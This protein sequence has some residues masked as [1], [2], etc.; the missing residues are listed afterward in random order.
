MIAVFL[1]LVRLC[2]FYKKSN[3]F[4]FRLYSERLFTLAV[5]F[6]YIPEERSETSWISNSYLL[7]LFT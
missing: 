6:Y 7:V 2:C 5:E 3:C 1:L 4:I